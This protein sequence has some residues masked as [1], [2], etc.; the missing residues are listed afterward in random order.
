MA[1]SEEILTKHKDVMTR[2]D[3][4]PVSL[5]T[6]YGQRTEGHLRHL[7]L[8]ED[9]A[10]ARAR[11]W[12]V[13]CFCIA[14]VTFVFPPHFPW[15]I[16][17]AIVGILGYFMRKGRSEMILGGEAA[18][19]KCGAFQILEGGN[20]EFPMAHFCSECRER[21]LIERLSEQGATQS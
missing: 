14:P 11:K 5:V 16:I 18:C 3:D 12:L 6:H 7:K 10:G 1:Y 17:T 15:P 2:G 4:L 8:T 13:I 21:S 20:A 9:E 19:P